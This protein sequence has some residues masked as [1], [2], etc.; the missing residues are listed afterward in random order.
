MKTLRV[1]LSGDLPE[2]LKR[3]PDYLY[4]V[5]DKLYLYAGQNLLDVNVAIVSE[6]PE[7]QIIGLIYILD[8]DGSVHRKTDYE[9]VTIAEIED[10]S[11]IE[12]LKKAGTMYYINAD[13]RYMDS[14]RRTLTL[15]YNNGNYE[16]SVAAKNDAKFNDNTILKYNTD[17]NRFELYSEQDEEFIDFSKPFR[18][19]ETSTVKM[20]AD[21]PKLSAN[22]K[23]SS[24]IGN[25]L[26][27]SSDGLYIKSNGLVDRETFDKWTEDVDE[28]KKYA[29]DIL[30]KVDSELAEA[31]KLVTTEAITKEI[32]DQLIYKYPDI[33]TAISNYDKVV[34]ELD[35]MQDEIISYSSNAVSTAA[36]KIDSTIEKYSSW[37]ELDSSHYTYANEVNYYEK[38]EKYY[39]QE[40]SAKEKLTL[41]TTAIYQYLADIDKDGRDKA[42]KKFVDA[43][44]SIYLNSQ[45]ENRKIADIAMGVYLNENN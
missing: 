32:N 6:I 44:M 40:L 33:E 3:D 45:E 21:G 4:F 20:I 9:D 36:N 10:S 28:F 35:G 22:I 16:L 43:A 25:L 37:D 39:Y 42:N 19:K 23:I 11:Q 24:M 29:H 18:G 34:E 8:T 12:L 14:Q 7:E 2:L 41:I 30:D 27:A 38:A 15:P 13:H 31:Q 5:Y 1:C 17:K 26:K